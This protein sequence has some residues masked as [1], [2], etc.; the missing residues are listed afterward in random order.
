MDEPTRL[1]FPNQAALDEYIFRQAV[2]DLRERKGWTQ[3]QLAVKLQEAGLEEYRQ[4]TVA[5]LEKGT[6]AVRLGESGVIAKTLGV[7]VEEMLL[8]PESLFRVEQLHSVI[9]NHFHSINALLTAMISFLNTSSVAALYR[10]SKEEY[11]EYKTEET[12]DFDYETTINRRFEWLEAPSNFDIFLIL[13]IALHSSVK[14][15]GFNQNY[16]PDFLDSLKNTDLVGL[17]DEIQ[18][19]SWYPPLNSPDE[20]E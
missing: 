17:V 9:D 13:K 14:R 3:N 11:L 8:P 2:K 10:D 12:A 6:R 5:R 20:N 15:P 7:T 1:D 19:S 18:N 4:T 16:L